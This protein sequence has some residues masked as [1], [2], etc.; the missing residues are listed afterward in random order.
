[1]G[2]FE[3]N[4]RRLFEIIEASKENDDASRAYDF[5]MLTAIIVG[6][7]PLMMKTENIYTQLI[8]IF[9]AI[10]FLVDYSLRFYTADYKMGV[11]CVRAYVAY[12]IMPM[13]IID[14]LSV[15]PLL[16]VFLGGS[17]IIGIFRIFRVFRVLKLIRYSKTMVII[18]NV[19]RRVKK[20]LMAVLILTIIYTLV[21]AM[22]IFQLEPDL[23]N[24]FFDAVYWAI[25]SITTI[26][27]GDI[28]PITT[29]GRLITMFSA[30][31]GIAIIALPSGII[32]AGYM[33]EIRRK[34]SKLEL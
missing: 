7:I 13:S 23:F 1:M 24:N 14:L 10:I 15:V 34:K 26:G 3:T 30:I 12:V 9:T 2:E 31:M 20:Q 4:K 28:S 5:L 21:S 11:K 17:K 25:I 32:T 6:M 19:L 22:L 8:D 29:L 27:Y 16:S 18:A 33:D